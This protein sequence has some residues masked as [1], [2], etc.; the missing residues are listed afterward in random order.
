MEGITGFVYRNTHYRFF[1]DT[2][3]YYMPFAAANHT[4][5]F[6]SREYTD[7]APENNSGIPVIP[8]I[9][10][11][12]A[13]DFVWAAHAIEE[14]GYDEI[15][16]NFGCS[17]PTISKKKRGAG[18]LLYPDELDRCLDEM[19]SRL[20]QESP[21]LKISI[22]TRIGYDDPSEAERIFA[23][24]EKYPLS[25]LI[26]HPRTRADLYR[27]HPNLQVFEEVLSKS[28][29]K[30]IYNGDLKTATDCRGI[31]EQ[32]PE[33]D[34]LML[35]R[36]L[37]RNPAL[38]REMHGGAPITS[39][40]LREFHDCLYDSYSE[41]FSGRNVIV[42]RMKELWAYMIDLFEDCDKERKALFKSGNR[43]EYEAAV[44]ILFNLCRLKTH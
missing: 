6:K 13:D 29:H 33:T 10:A 11:G 32:F 25:E 9:L 1:S 20:N 43:A 4:H 23:I 31:L 7:M 16:L 15:N 27:N 21:Q 40:E 42:N 37:L 18:F 12:R 36:G 44:R 38:I 5:S 30:I 35:G 2:D 17:V 24:Y 41:S 39:K 8:Q 14:L 22:K 26:I 34:G 3:R 19:F 28:R